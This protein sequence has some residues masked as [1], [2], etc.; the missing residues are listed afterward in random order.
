MTLRIAMAI[1][2]AAWT[3]LLLGTAFTYASARRLLVAE[4]DNSILVRALAA[5][6]TGDAPLA[7]GDRF[8]VQDRTGRTVVRPSARVNASSPT[9]IRREFT[10]SDARERMRTLWIELRVEGETRTIVY[11]APA[12]VLDRILSAL[13]VRV[14]ATGLLGA[15]AIAGIAWVVSRH[16]T[17]PLRTMAQAIGQVDERSLDRRI[18][19]RQMPT[20]LQPV[21]TR[22]N[23]MLERIEEAFA[24]RS[25]LSRMR[26]MSCARR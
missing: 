19:H 7:E 10:T 15:V 3:T 9:V 18:D 11:S 20:E 22:V 21:A 2:V 14:A 8:I 12:Q 4:L 6:G 1:L 16:A 13:L 24:R 25:S 5:V 17:R 26:L 23:G